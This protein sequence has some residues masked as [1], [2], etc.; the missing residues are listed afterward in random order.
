MG[1]ADRD[2]FVAAKQA[3]GIPYTNVTHN[4]T[5]NYNSTHN[6]MNQQDVHNQAMSMLQPHGTQFGTFMHQNRLNQEA[7]MYLLMKHI[8]TNSGQPQEFW[9]W[10]PAWWRC[11]S[12]HG[13]RWSHQASEIAE[14]GDAL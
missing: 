2:R 13:W 11:W 8:R 4:T 7:M 12:H 6:T 9:A 1:A 5:N 10:E 14:E 3:P